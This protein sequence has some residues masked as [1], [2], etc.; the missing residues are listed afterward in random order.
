MGG[1]GQSFLK[2]IL[3]AAGA[4]VVMLILTNLPILS[5]LELKRFRPKADG[6]KTKIFAQSGYASVIATGC[7]S[8]Q[9]GRGGPRIRS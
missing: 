5:L 7:G 1:K 3:I 4:F 9:C 8:P 2:V 6:H